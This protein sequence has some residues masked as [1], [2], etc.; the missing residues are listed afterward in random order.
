MMTRPRR[1]HLAAVLAALILAVTAW[2]RSEEIDLV[3][4][5]SQDPYPEFS[6]SGAGAILMAIARQAYLDAAGI[7]TPSSLDLPESENRPA[8]PRD[9]PSSPVWP[10]GPT[11]LILCL[12]LDDDVLG[13][14][15]GRLPASEDLAEAIANLGARLPTSRSRG[16]PKT[17]RPARQR[18]V[19]LEAAF[20]TEVQPFLQESAGAARK[21][22]KLPGGIEAS[23]VG[24]VV[25]GLGGEAVTFPGEAPSPAAAMRIA[26]K[27]GLKESRD[28]GMELWWYRPAKIGSVPLFNP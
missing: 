1:S 27:A 12:K 8:G 14:E 17:L 11:G 2:A 22:P 5:R 13:C 6:A 3:P 15:G 10:V 26:R 9:D 23:L 25:D 24:F 20:V 16:M 21:K 4:G 28:R 7:E 19:R 18:R